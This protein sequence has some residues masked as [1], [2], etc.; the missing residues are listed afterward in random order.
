MKKAFQ[1]VNIKLKESLFLVGFTGEGKTTNG[2]LLSGCTLLASEPDDPRDTQLK[3]TPIDNDSRQIGQSL[4]HSTT[5]LPNLFLRFKQQPQDVTDEDENYL[6][7]FG[8]LTPIPQGFIAND[9]SMSER[10]RVS[11]GLRDDGFGNLE[12]DPDAGE[13]VKYIWDTPGF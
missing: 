1:D 13:L 8:M 4:V 11:Y 9:D 6:D 10:S 5:T 3:I 12:R 7:P 2:H